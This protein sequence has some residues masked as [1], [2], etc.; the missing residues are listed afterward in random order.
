[1]QDLSPVSGKTRA[2]S[3][4]YALQNPSS[5]SE[6]RPTSL[7]ISPA[8]YN[9]TTTKPLLPTSTRD[10]SRSESPTSPNPPVHPNRPQP[11]LR[12]RQSHPRH[13]CHNTRKSCLESHDPLPIIHRRTIRRHVGRS[14][15][16]INRQ[17]R[18]PTSRHGLVD[19]LIDR[20][21]P[22]TRSW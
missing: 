13:A 15:L 18:Q 11:H 8:T 16:R 14:S 5:G 3:R 4:K 19:R 22:P 21:R 12:D 20:Q 1:M 2:Q 7:N 9:N 17:R 6:L 10:P